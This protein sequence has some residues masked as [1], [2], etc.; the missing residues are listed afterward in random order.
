MSIDE[1]EQNEHSESTTNTPLLDRPDVQ[2]TLLAYAWEQ[3]SRLG[4]G[5]V[6][7]NRGM[8]LEYVT[9]AQYLDFVAKLRSDGFVVTHGV[10]EVPEDLLT[11]DPTCSAGILVIGV[12]RSSGKRETL[13]YI[14]ESARPMMA[15]KTSWS[16]SL[17]DPTRLL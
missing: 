4:R 3:Y 5:V 2:E 7:L 14:A 12:N 13:L 10:K 17:N 9:T 15:N 16:P 11:Y 1:L 6:V 8:E